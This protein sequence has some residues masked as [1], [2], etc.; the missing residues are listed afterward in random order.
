MLPAVILLAIADL[1]ELRCQAGAVSAVIR[2]ADDT[3]PFVLETPDGRRFRTLGTDFIHVNTWKAAESLR[4][5]LQQSQSVPYFEITNTKRGETIIAQLIEERVF[6]D[7]CTERE[8]GDTAGW[9][10]FLSGPGAHP[11]VMFDWSEGALMGPTTTTAN[12]AAASGRLRFTAPIATGTFR[13]EGKMRPHELVGML[14][15]P[16]QRVPHIVRLAETSQALAE[17]PSSTCKPRK[18]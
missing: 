6:A 14:S 11:R 2:D 7:T 5:C 15:E 17:H 18:Q 4:I 3:A 12:Y 16:W 13:F 10:V 1:P 9:I 8:S